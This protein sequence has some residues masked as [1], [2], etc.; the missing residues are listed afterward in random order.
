M[1]QQILHR[2]TLPSQRALAARN[3]HQGPEFHYVSFVM[4]RL[5]LHKMIVCA[6]CGKAVVDGAF[7]IMRQATVRIASTPHGTANLM[8]DAEFAAS[9]SDFAPHAEIGLGIV[10]N[11]SAA[12]RQFRAGLTRGANAAARRQRSSVVG[13]HAHRRPSP[14]VAR[15]GRRQLRL[16]PRHASAVGGKPVRAHHVRGRAAS[17]AG[18]AERTAI[19]RGADAEARAD[20]L[21]GAY[22]RRGWMRPLQGEDARRRRYGH[23]AA[24]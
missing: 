11:H 14:G 20:P 23:A 5:K 10:E 17:R 15:G 7:L 18:C 22:N 4:R 21:T 13:V 8:I 16:A 12:S 2:L 19:P 1:P 24:C 6:G 9:H 3:I